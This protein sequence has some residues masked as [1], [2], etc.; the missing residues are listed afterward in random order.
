MLAL[1]LLNTTV[2]FGFPVR[3]P[4]QSGLDLEWD[5]MLDL[6]DVIYSTDLSQI[7]P[8][9]LLDLGIFYTG[10]GTLLYP[11]SHTLEDGN[12]NV[13]KWHYDISNKTAVPPAD[14]LRVRS[15]EEFA[16]TSI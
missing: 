3:L 14:F 12:V 6:A 13:I 15:E 8:R 16:T 10:I 11:I 7:K 4:D 5:V 2:A 9:P 1:L